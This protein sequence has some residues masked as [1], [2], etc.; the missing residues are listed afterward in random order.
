MIDPR[1]RPLL[2]VLLAL[3]AGCAADRP[4]AGALG[5]FRAAH[6]RPEAPRAVP[7][8]ALVESLRDRHELIAARDVALDLAAARPDDPVALRLASRAESDFLVV[9]AADDAMADARASAA[10]SALDFAERAR[11]AGADEAAAWSQLAW[12]QGAVTHLMPMF[13]RADHARVVLRSVD[14]ALARDD[15]DATAWATLAT[16]RLRLATLPWIADLFAVGAPEATVDDAIAAA[17]RAVAAEP[18][19]ASALLL[20]KA[21]DEAGRG[22]EAAAAV[23]S[24]LEDDRILPRD[25]WFE[26]EARRRSGLT[27]GAGARTTP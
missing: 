16:L 23:R 2:L 17:Q 6:W 11:A 14:E 12:A 21:L 20:A 5:V 3:P 4:D 19:L 15:G 10:W 7:D 1:V 8:P 13:S 24:A 22:D 18:S 25:P 27:P 26:D 9:T